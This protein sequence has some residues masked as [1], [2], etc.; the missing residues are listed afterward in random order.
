LRPERLDSYEAGLKNRLFD[1][2][3]I[4]NFA[5]FYYD[6]SNITVRSAVAN[7]ATTFD[8]VNAATARIYGLDVDMTAQITPDFSLSGGLEVLHAEFTR[9]P[10]TTSLIPAPA[11]GN[12]QTTVVATGNTL[13]NAPK[14]SANLGGSYRL[15]LD[16]RHGELKL[17]ANLVYRSKIFFEADNTREQTRYALLNAAL[18][19]T[20]PEKDWSVKVWA[21]NLGDTRY[22]LSRFA[23]AFTDLSVF[24]EPRSVGVTLGYQLGGH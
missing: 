5:G 13:P 6:Y 2:R 19:W 7:A 16:A 18:V 21:R 9:F 1:R 22:K 4:L 12:R 23:T 17:S 10:I 3:L 11:G 8:L 20:A 24:G 14:L 15:P